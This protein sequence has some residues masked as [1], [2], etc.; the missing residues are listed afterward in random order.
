MRVYLLFKRKNE[1]N[2]MLCEY[3]HFFFRCRTGSPSGRL[4]ASTYITHTADG[5]GTLPWIGDLVVSLCAHTEG[6]PAARRR[7][8]RRKIPL[9]P[10]PA[11][12]FA[13]RNCAFCSQW[14]VVGGSYV[15]ICLLLLL[16][17]TRLVAFPAFRAIAQ[18]LCL[19]RC[20]LGKLEIVSRWHLC[21]F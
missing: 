2:V 18:A 6:H 16:P 11:A 10:A 9:F 20:P 21:S 15:W 3:V 17:S 1:R 8:S 7:D 13:S 14:G 19:D 5:D 4:R 12:R